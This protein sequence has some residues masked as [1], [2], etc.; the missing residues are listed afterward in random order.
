M[1]HCTHTLRAPC[2]WPYQPTA[3]APRRR[4][5]AC[6][7]EVAEEH[8]KDL[9]DKKF[10]PDLIGYI[11]SGPVVGMVSHLGLR[12][13]AMLRRVG[14]AVRGGAHAAG[15]LAEGA[16]PS[17]CCMSIALPDWVG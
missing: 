1:E 4:S 16:V 11:L 10:F 14:C 9:K 6:C 13:L 17:A 8:Y 15:W 3:H 7:R 5:S 2:A 12:C